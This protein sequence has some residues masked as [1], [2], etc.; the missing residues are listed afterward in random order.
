MLFNSHSHFHMILENSWK[1][2]DYLEKF[3]KKSLVEILE[4]NERNWVKYTSLI[5]SDIANCQK[6]VELSKLDSSL[7]CV[8][9]LHPEDHQ[10]EVELKN[11]ENHLEIM[12]NL[13]KNNLEKIKAIWEIW[14]DFHYLDEDNSEHKKRQIEI[15]K[16]FFEKQ[17]E[18][19]KNYNLPIIIHTRDAWDDTIEIIKKLKIEKFVIHCFSENLEFAK[20]IIEIS[21]NSY[22]GFAGMITYKSASDLREIISQIP[23]NRILIE[24]DDPFL[25]PQAHRWKTNYPSYVRY[26]LAQIQEI[27]NENLLEIEEQI[28]QNSLKFF[29]IKYEQ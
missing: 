18:L 10:E 12:E 28:W 24:T 19:A 7:F 16:I 23:L 3:E 27:R 4:D 9:W 29:D 26:I 25:A 14:L 1:N 15:Q 5:W 8:I 11:L 22:L 6:I 20:N 21:P 17:V 2:W 13:I